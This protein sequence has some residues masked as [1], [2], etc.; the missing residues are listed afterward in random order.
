MLTA[1]SMDGL[2]AYGYIENGGGPDEELEDC[3]AGAQAAG[4]AE[5]TLPYTCRFWY[6]CEA[7][8]Q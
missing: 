7:Q 5:Q 8:L 6:R 3:Q 1:A 4:K 2:L